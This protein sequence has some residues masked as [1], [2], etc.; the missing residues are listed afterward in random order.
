VTRAAGERAVVRQAV[1]AEKASAEGELQRIGRGRF[2]DG[3][4]RLLFRG[5]RSDRRLE[6]GGLRCRCPHRHQ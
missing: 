1:I 4:N 5:K 3:R 2:R 6:V